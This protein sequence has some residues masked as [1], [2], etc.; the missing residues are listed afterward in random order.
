[1]GIITEA[2]NS[3][4][5]IVRKAH[6]QIVRAQERKWFICPIKEFVL[7]IPATYPDDTQD[8]KTTDSE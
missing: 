7:L 1:M 5:G 4:D 2:V 3:E 8:E 6:V